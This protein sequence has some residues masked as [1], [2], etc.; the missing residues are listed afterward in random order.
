M[1]FLNSTPSKSLQ[2][3]KVQSTN[4]HGH[5][6]T[7][8]FSADSAQA[9]MRRNG[10]WTQAH[11]NL[12]LRC[13]SRMAGTSRR[14]RMPPFSSQPFHPRSAWKRTGRRHPDA[15]ERRKAASLENRHYLASNRFRHR[16]ASCFTSDGWRGLARPPR[17]TFLVGSI[18]SAFVSARRSS[19]R[20]PDIV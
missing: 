12:V 1:T 6:Q 16:G 20:G 18:G 4:E 14:L 19:K 8:N 15:G 17:W 5:M 3:P 11:P 13:H 7:G 9:R 10:F 2:V